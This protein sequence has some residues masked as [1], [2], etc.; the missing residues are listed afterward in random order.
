[1]ASISPTQRTLAALRADGWTVAIVE[2]WNPHARIR[3]DL[4]GFVDL[5]ALKPGRTLAVQACAGASFAARIAKI[6]EADLVGR[7]REA[8]WE[9][10]VWGWRKLKTG[11]APKIADLS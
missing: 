8:G 10:Q 9:I 5:V 3:Q 4:W 1:M 7:V 2:H 11:W 6:T